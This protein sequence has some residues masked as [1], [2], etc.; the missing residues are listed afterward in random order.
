[1]SDQVIACAEIA[2]HDTPD[3]GMTNAITYL[4]RPGQP[5]VSDASGEHP[6][7]LFIPVT[8]TREELRSDLASLDQ[9]WADHERF[10]LGLPVA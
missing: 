8:R 4:V 9:D 7:E 5:L 2:L 1:M 6:G 3:G 10:A